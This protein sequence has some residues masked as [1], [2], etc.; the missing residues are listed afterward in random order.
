MSHPWLAIASE[1]LVTYF[2][3]LLPTRRLPK[4]LSFKGAGDGWNI[5]PPQ[6]LFIPS[7]FAAW[8]CL[9]ILRERGPPLLLWPYRIQ[10]MQQLHHF[11]KCAPGTRSL[12]RNQERLHQPRPQTVKQIQIETCDLVKYVQSLPRNQQW[13][14]KNQ[15]HMTGVFLPP[16]G[17]EPL[18]PLHHRKWAMPFVL[19]LAHLLETTWCWKIIKE[20]V[21]KAERFYCPVN[22]HG[23]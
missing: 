15:H 7:R 10:Q 17:P 2:L 9:Q 23:I 3:S 16:F 11:W 18:H 22:T 13:A 21:L 5:E 12:P 19:V 8:L 1:S 4:F 6:N 14:S 20:P